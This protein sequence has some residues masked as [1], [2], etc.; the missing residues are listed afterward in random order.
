MDDFQKATQAELK[1]R[2]TNLEERNE[3]LNNLIELDNIQLTKLRTQL[4]D[5][6]KI[7]NTI[8][9][10]TRYVPTTFPTVMIW[11][12]LINDYRNIYYPN[13]ANNPDNCLACMAPDEYDLK[14]TCKPK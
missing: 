6:E 1:A 7:I 9:N 4:S 10:D 14:H 12:G 3:R 5:A 8:D 11:H 13:P 2:F